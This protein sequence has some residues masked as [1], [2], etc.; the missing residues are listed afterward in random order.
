MPCGLAPGDA[1]RWPQAAFLRQ[2]TNDATD[3]RIKA[4]RGCGQVLLCATCA[5][6]HSSTNCMPHVCILHRCSAISCLPC[7]VQPYYVRTTTASLSRRK[8]SMVRPQSELAIVTSDM[9]RIPQYVAALLWLVSLA[10]CICRPAV[11]AMHAL[12]CAHCCI[13]NWL[14]VLYL[15]GDNAECM[16]GAASSFSLRAAV[17]PA[18]EG[19]RGVLGRDI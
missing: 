11:H 18:P 14:L 7:H 6:L 17:D 12:C 19:S 2:H 3:A 8:W 10:C 15:A 9:L 1:L 13:P 16:V 5:A 4:L